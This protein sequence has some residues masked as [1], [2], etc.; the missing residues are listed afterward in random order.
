MS[1]IDF[2]ET[3]AQTTWTITSME[4][5]VQG[6]PVTDRWKDLLTHGKF[7]PWAFLPDIDR[8]VPSFN[9]QNSLG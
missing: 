1:D 8:Y 9:G 3:F 4:T 5:F 7:Y 6:V 2:N